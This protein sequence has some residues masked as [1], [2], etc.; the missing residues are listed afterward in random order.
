MTERNGGAVRLGRRLPE[1]GISRRPRGVFRVRG[2]GG[3]AHSMEVKAPFRRDRS[4]EVAIVCAVGAPAVVEMRDGEMKGHD[5]KQLAQDGEQR[6]GVGSARYRDHHTLARL[7]NA[8]QT[9]GDGDA[10][11]KHHRNGGGK[12]RTC[13]IPGM[14][15]LLYH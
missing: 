12:D 2:I 14:G 7:E 1:E 6:Q 11:G 3:R 9:D 15:R 5:G 13:D 4:D 10:A 8:M